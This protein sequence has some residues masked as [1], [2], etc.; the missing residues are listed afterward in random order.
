MDRTL[1]ALAAG[2]R[3][4]EAGDY[5]AAVAEYSEALSCA[6]LSSDEAE[7]LIRGRVMLG[8]SLTDLGEYEE[9]L[10]MLDRAM[11]VVPENLRGII[12]REMAR[13]HLGLGKTESATKHI[14]HAIQM[15]PERDLAERGITLSCSGSIYASQSE[16]LRALEV[17]GLAD[18]LLQRGDNRQYELYNLL[19]YLAA[20]LSNEEFIFAHSLVERAERLARD[21][22]NKSHEDRLAEM[23]LSIHKELARAD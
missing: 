15:I 5:A 12:N 8:V 21:V 10:D 6:P 9:A 19:D 11:T 18:Q 23:V 17:F 7:I 13:A 20:L 3:L 22:G 14:F 4:R 2:D 16:M 1:E